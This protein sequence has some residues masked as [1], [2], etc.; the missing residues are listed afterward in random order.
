[1]KRICF[2]VLT[3]MMLYS[4]AAGMSHK[5][6]VND[7]PMLIGTIGQ[8]EL[9]K[10]FPVFK[11]NH[12]RYTPNDSVVASI[13]DH[14]GSIHIEIFLGTWCGDSK[15]N[16]A[17]FLKTLELAGW[18]DLSYTMHALDRTKRDKDGLAEKYKIVRVPT[19]IFLKDGKEIGRITEQPVQTIEEDIL[20]ILR[21]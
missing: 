1:M 12:D 18:K 2:A 20:A 4:C 16:L 3:G 8:D 6:I 14:V 21:Q 11:T 17:Y 9:F 5:Q 7:E 13:R 10:E 15:R 19:M